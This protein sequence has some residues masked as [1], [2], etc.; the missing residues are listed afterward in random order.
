M[1]LKTPGRNISL[2]A[3]CAIARL[4]PTPNRNILHICLRFMTR[5]PC[6]SYRIVAIESAC[7][8]FCPKT[9]KST[10]RGR[11]SRSRR[12]MYRRRESATWGFTGRCWSKEPQIAA[13]ASFCSS[14]PAL[15][16]SFVRFR[17]EFS[18]R[19][20][21][22]GCVRVALGRVRGVAQGTPAPWRAGT[23]LGWAWRA[24]ARGAVRLG[25]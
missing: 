19:C 15:Y 23:M 7:R 18:T 5:C 20:S 3:T 17:L 1:F 11:W 2:A 21:L 9:P 8:F 16:R 14:R 25:P 4:A 6:R 13:Q 24:E 12:F 10:V 22:G